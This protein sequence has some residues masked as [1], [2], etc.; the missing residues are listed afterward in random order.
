MAKLLATLFHALMLQHALPCTALQLLML[1]TSVPSALLT[2]NVVLECFVEP[3]T[4]QESAKMDA[5][6]HF[7]MTPL[8]A[9][10]VN[11]AT[12]L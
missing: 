7:Q 8:N 11:I 12:L 6:F 10:R 4:T 5:P 1:K 2:K 3:V 9:L